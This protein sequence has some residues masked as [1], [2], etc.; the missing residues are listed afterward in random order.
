MEVALFLARPWSPAGHRKTR[1]G[2]PNAGYQPSV[3]ALM[4]R[5]SEISESEICG[6]EDMLLL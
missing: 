5:I 2:L 6:R 4:G 1:A 3:R